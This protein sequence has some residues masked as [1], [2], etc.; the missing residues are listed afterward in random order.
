MSNRIS[1]IACCRL[2]QKKKNEES[3]DMLSIDNK[4]YM[5]KQSKNYKLTQTTYII[6]YILN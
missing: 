5:I 6:I 2:D 3:I 1:S 4:N